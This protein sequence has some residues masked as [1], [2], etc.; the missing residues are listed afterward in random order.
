[1]FM[2]QL[3]N[4]YRYGLFT[5]LY[6]SEG[7]EGEMLTEYAEKEWKHERHV[8][9]TPVQVINEVKEHGTK[10]VAAIRL[11]S[12]S[13]KKNQAEFERLKN[14]MEIYDALAN[15]YAEKALAALDVLRYKYSTDLVDLEKGYGHL[16]KSLEYFQQLVQLTA[17]S[18]LYANSMQ[19]QQRKI[20][21]GGDNGVNKTWKE[22]FPYYQKELITFRR[23]I[24]SLKLPNHET[25]N[26][27]GTIFKNA[28][29]TILT[30]PESFYSIAAGKEIFTDTATYIKDFAE[31]LKEL[32]GLKLSRSKQISEGTVLKFNNS[33]PVKVVVGYYNSKDQKFLQPPE[34]ETDATANDHG[35]AEVKISNALIISG[36]PPVNI[37]TYSFPA[38]ANT[39]VLGKG[40]CLVLG[41]VD[42]TT[43]FPARDAGLVTGG[44]KKELDWLFE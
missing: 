43:P 38:G 6:N 41:F 28:D 26:T 39:L 4:P 24:D 12:P 7:P 11:A 3:I 37:H 35:Q 9:E 10:A 16:E 25:T 21:I 40:A 1:M 32:N 34:L 17:N 29:V 14:D 31:E 44:V 23:K 42:D 18:Y 33:K 8:G 19:T 15:H 22:L 36:M 20:P 30:K 5:L 2:T 13:V 27:P